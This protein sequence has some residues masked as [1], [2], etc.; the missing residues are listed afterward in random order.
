MSKTGFQSSRKM[1]K[2]TFPWRLM[3]G[4]YILVVQVTCGGDPSQTSMQRMRVH[5]ESV[6]ASM[7]RKGHGK[8][9][10]LTFGGSCGYKAG[11][12]NVNLYFAPAQKPLS[13]LIVTLKWLKSLGLG[14]SMVATD[15]PS[16][17]A[18]SAMPAG[19]ASTKGK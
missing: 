8:T 3:F 15:P 12:T 4:W 11:M 1:F 6:R 17:S 10:F 13:G 14:N 19:H 5:K 2:Q 7:Q 9:A 18:M 16:R